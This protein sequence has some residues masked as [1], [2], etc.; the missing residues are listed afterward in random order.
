MAK[1]L[2]Y[3]KMYLFA[4][5]LGY[6]ARE[7]ERLRRMVTFIALIYARAWLTAPLA[8]DAPVRDLQLCRD[9]QRL[10]DVNQPT[11]DQ[12]RCRGATTP[13]S[14]P[15]AAD[16]GAEPAASDAVGEGERQALAEALLS[17][18]ESA[19]P[20]DAALCLRDTPTS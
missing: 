17:Q 10:R 5:Q 2:Y 16:G 3:I 13:H 8:A 12:P 11:A 19:D 7:Q 6:D 1:V 14:L 15:P 18:P 4:G 20:E 9:L